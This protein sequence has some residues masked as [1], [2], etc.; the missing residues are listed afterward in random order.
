MDFREIAD[1]L[2]Q[3][4][5]PDFADVATVGVPERCCGRTKHRPGRSPKGGCTVRRSRPPTAE[6]PRAL[7]AVGDMLPTLPGPPDLEP[8]PP[9]SALVISDMSR[10]RR[11]LGLP[12]TELRGM[13]PLDAHALIT[14]P[15]GGRRPHVGRAR[16][17][18]DRYAW[19]LR[20]RRDRSVRGDLRRADR[21][22]STTP[23]GT[24]ARAPRRSRLQRSLLP[25]GMPRI[26][27]ARHRPWSTYVPA[28]GDVGV[29]GDWYDAI[30]LIPRARP[31]W[32]GTWPS[33]ACASAAMGRPARRRPDHRPTSTRTLGAS[34]T[35][36][37]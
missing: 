9:G 22:P 4:L 30:P 34:G 16:R 37:T 3:V 18:A 36:T 15:I 10:L 35:W 13:M 2:V 6:R 19:S 23:D 5:V 11:A 27:A 28:R 33:T 1:A 31:S 12:D 7:T 17:L 8:P 26:A 32:S 21:W 20:R 29:G 24:R 14:A 25:S